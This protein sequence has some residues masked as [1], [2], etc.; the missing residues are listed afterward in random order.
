MDH[1]VQS[2]LVAFGGVQCGYC[3]PGFVM[4]ASSLVAEHQH[5]S[6]DEVRDG[7]SG[8]IC[9]CTGYESIVEALIEVSGVEA[10]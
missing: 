8:N 6:S 3:T 4:C 1:M 2:E 7:L 10:S 5:L 9:R